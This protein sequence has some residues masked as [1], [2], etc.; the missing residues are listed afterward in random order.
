M[1]RIAISIALSVAGMA[2]APAVAG[3]ESKCAPLGLLG[4]YR[5]HDLGDRSWQI[6]VLGNGIAG[7]GFVRNCTLERAGAIASAQGFPRFA[8]VTFKSSLSAFR[9]SGG[10]A[11]GS[12]KA[13]IKLLRAGETAEAIDADQVTYFDTATRRMERDDWFVPTTDVAFAELR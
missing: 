11:R 9:G 13:V 4:G 2:G 7:A 12:S 10:F 6:S 5:Q 8:V 3:L 1:K